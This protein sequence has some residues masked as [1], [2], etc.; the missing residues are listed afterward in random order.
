VRESDSSTKNRQAG[1]VS[2]GDSLVTLHWLYSVEQR[3][4][5]PIKWLVLLFVIAL[6]LLEN[7]ALLIDPQQLDHEIL[8]TLISYAVLT[9]IFTWLFLG[10]VVPVRFFRPFGYLSLFCDVAFVCLLANQ[11]GGLNSNFYYLLFLMV[12]RSAA[13]FQDPFRKFCADLLMTIIYLVCAVPETEPPEAGP[14]AFLVL[15]VT[16]L[17]GVILMSSFLVRVFTAQQSQFRS[18][19]ER[20]RYQSEQN[21]QVLSAMTDAVL[22]FDKSQQLRLCNLSAE[23]LLAGLLGILPSQRGS[24]ISKHGTPTIWNEPPKLFGATRLSHWE[25]SDF[26]FWTN[27]TPDQIASP[28]DKLLEE[29]RFAPDHRLDAR[30]ISLT[31]SKGKKRSLIASVAALGEAGEERLGWLLLLKDISDY[32]SLEQQLLSSEKLAAVGRLAAGLAHEL[33]NPLGIIN[34]CATHMVKKTDAD[35]QLREEAEVLASESERCRQILRQLL[36]FASQEQ[37]HL[38]DIDLKTL[39][40]KCVN[41]VAFQAKDDVQINFDPPAFEAACFTDENLLTQAI[42]NLL[43]NAVQSINKEGNVAISLD[44]SGSEGYLIKVQDN[45]CGMGKETRARIFDP[46]FTT[47]ATGT[48]LGLAITQ[49]IIHRLGGNIEVDSQPGQ[50]TAFSITLPERIEDFGPELERA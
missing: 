23:I 16:L 11:T 49:R 32:Q 30:P 39:L 47:K 34:S 20:L 45:G 8:G 36:S 38:N 27:L 46:F 19:Y 6:L 21:R 17:V 5:I 13:L 4:V 28:I 37:L 42:V 31:D 33:G 10:R 40:E 15:Q 44:E 7:R 3:T 35:S 2:L 48:G 26:L 29:T 14:T 1:A 22:V 50:G 24:L 41:L 12:L 18:I 43:L 25:S 9:G